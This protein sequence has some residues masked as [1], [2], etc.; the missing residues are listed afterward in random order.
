MSEII[1]GKEC[2]ITENNIHIKDSYTVNDKYEMSEILTEIK[3]NH[4]E[5]KVFDIRKWD[6]LLSEWKCHNRLY[7]LGI[8]KTRTGSVDLDSF[9]PWWRR[10]LYA[11]LGI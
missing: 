4:P 10:I 2:T 1:H 6:N 8:F 3:I 11:I 5:C 9:E 7:K